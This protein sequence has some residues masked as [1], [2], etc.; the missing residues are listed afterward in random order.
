MRVTTQ[1]TPFGRCTDGHASNR[2][3]GRHGGIDDA[4]RKIKISFHEF[5]YAA[6]VGALESGDL[7]PVTAGRPEEGH[8]SLRSRPRLE[9][10]RDLAQD[11]RGPPAAVLRHAAGGA[12]MPGGR[13]P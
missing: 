12:G 5:G 3:S 10:V 11:R 8:L 7:E 1:T 6:D 4:K 9:E 2:V 13:D